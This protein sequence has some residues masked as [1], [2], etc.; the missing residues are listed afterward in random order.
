MFRLTRERV[1]LNEEGRVTFLPDGTVQTEV[2]AS[3]VTFPTEGLDMTPYL[4]P[5]SPYRK[6][7]RESRSYRLCAVIDRPSG[8]S[9]TKS[10]HYIAVTR[11]PG[12]SSW[13]KYNDAIVSP[14]DF[15]GRDSIFKT[16]V[17]LV[18]TTYS[19]LEFA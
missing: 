7:S 6:H 2:D 19:K 8:G 3:P 16:A 13:N 1:V 9:S 10:G 12:T 14:Y 17:V 5:A 18:Y 11:Q 4:H 15:S